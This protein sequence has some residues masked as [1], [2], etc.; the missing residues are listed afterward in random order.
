MYRRGITQ[1]T[2][3]IKVP[4]DAICPAC[5]KHV[6]PNP[7]DESK[8]CVVAKIG[9]E[10]FHAPCSA[11]VSYPTRREFLYPDKVIPTVSHDGSYVTRTVVQFIEPG[12]EAGE[13]GSFVLLACFAIFAAALLFTLSNVSV[14][15]NRSWSQLY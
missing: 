2:Q 8:S 3:S 13:E 15:G 11:H 12:K 5:N 9:E 6:L 4:Y 1:R 7:L 14:A 10:F